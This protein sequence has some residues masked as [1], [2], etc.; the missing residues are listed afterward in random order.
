[1]S[2]ELNYNVLGSPLIGREF[3]I[4]GAINKEH[5]Y[6]RRIKDAAERF[7]WNYYRLETEGKDGMADILVTRGDEYAFIEVKRQTKKVLISIEKDLAWQFGQLAFFKRCTRNKTRYI[8][9]VVKEH[10]AVWFTAPGASLPDFV[11]SF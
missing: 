2:E 11:T 5:D 8:L 3:P 4:R 1:M 10:N 7:G 6:Y 9:A